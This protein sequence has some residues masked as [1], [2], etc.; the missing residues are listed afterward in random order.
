MWIFVQLRIADRASQQ[1]EKHDP[2]NSGH[3]QPSIDFH[4]PH[5]Q[6]LPARSASTIALLRSSAG[7]AAESAAQGALDRLIG[8]KPEAKPPTA[9]PTPAANT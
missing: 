8:E 6:S 3:K 7:E 9:P 1:A 4:L 2:T 5:P